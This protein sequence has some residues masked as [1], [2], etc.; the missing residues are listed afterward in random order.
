LGIMIAPLPWPPEKERHVVL[1]SPEIPW[2]AGNVGRTCLG[3]GA[4]LHLIRPL[5]FSLDSHQ[6]RRAGLD[7]WHRVPLRVWERFE[8]LEAD[9]KPTVEEVALLTKGGAEPLWEL[10]KG[11]RLFLLFGSETRG[12]PEDLLRRFAGRTYRIPITGA[13]R[14]LNLSTSVGIALY[15]SLREPAGP[16]GYAG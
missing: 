10:P 13:I 7:Y 1:L 11:P 6:V 15:E 5:G 12:L 4:T 14:C 16:R 2:N 3:A 8:E 9:L